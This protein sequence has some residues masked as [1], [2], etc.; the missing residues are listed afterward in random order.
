MGEA[1]SLSRHKFFYHDKGWKILGRD[2]GRLVRQ[3]QSAQ[4]ATIEHPA[5]AAACSARSTQCI[6]RVRH[7]MQ[8]AY[9]AHD[10]TYDRVQCCALFRVTV[11]NTLHGHCSWALF[12]GYCL[13]KKMMTPGIWG[14]IVW[15]QSLGIHI[16][17]TRWGTV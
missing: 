5:G 14:V 9:C 11:R 7:S 3:R 16:P 6:V 4:C 10:L 12:M 1:K 17:R 8:C 15:Y 2:R 13:E